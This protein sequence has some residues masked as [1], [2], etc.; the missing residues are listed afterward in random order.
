MFV[1]GHFH[2]LGM[3][4]PHF[5]CNANRDVATTSLCFCN[6]LHLL[7]VLLVKVAPGTAFAS[8]SKHHFVVIGKAEQQVRK[9][10]QCGT[11]QTFLFNIK[12]NQISGRRMTTR[13]SSHPPP[14]NTS[15]TAQNTI[16]NLQN[17][18]MSHATV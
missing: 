17:L 4:K 15:R 6:E 7:H 18:S 1:S 9:A 16:Q 13:S 12:K 5:Q 2:V 8:W 3:R 14:R 11:R 10:S